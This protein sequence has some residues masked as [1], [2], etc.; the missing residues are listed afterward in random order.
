MSKWIIGVI[1]LLAIGSTILYLDQMKGRKASDAEHLSYVPA[2][3]LIFFSA[4]NNED[5]LEFVNNM[6]INAS[7][8]S[9]QIQMKHVSQILD[10]QDSPTARFFTTLFKPFMNGELQSFTDMQRIFGTSAK[11]PFLTYTDGIFPVIRVGLSNPENFWA[12]IENSVSESGWQY[13]TETILNQEVKT[14][15][16]DTK[17]S[18]NQ[19]KL[20]IHDH[21]N[22]ATITILSSID[23]EQSRQQRLALAPHPNSIKTS[24]EIDDLKNKYQFQD[25]F[26][27]FVHF[28]R[29]ADNLL[30]L[31]SG[32]LGQ[33]LNA[34]LP[35]EQKSN[36]TTSLSE[37]CKKD[38]AALAASVPRLAMGYKNLSYANKQLRGD[39]DVVLELTN[40]NIKNELSLLRGH[41]PAHSKDIQDKIFTAG[42]GVNFTTVTPA[43]TN[44]WTQFVNAEFQCEK[45]HEAQDFARKGNPAMLAMF[46]GMAQGIKGLGVSLFE[47]DWNPQQMVVNKLSALVSVASESP[48]T[49][50]GMTS[51]IPM[52]SGLQIPADG[53][54]VEVPLAMLP[55]NSKISAAI[56]GNHF[57]VYTEDLSD[58]AAA[59]ETEV[60][61]TNGLS[62]FGINYR[63]FSKISGIT[64]TA[65]I[66][67]AARCISNEELRHIFSTMP[68][69]LL[70]VT[71]SS[72]NGL[73]FR[74]SMTLDTVTHSKA[75]LVGQHQVEYL[76][77]NC[78]WQ[79]AGQEILTVD[80]NGNYIERDESDSCDVF[81]SQ[82]NWKEEGQR[83]VF[84]PTKESS[85]ESCADEMADGELE[86]YDC[87]LMN[88]SGNQFQCLFDAGTEDAA[89]YRYT[90][91]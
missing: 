75:A 23:S 35:E 4:K 28:S 83:I 78:Q 37:N 49:I 3:T 53:T 48:Q 73:E 27:S 51:M 16:F 72:D 65:G 61:E 58:S 9:Q 22:I 66:S 39:F 17:D 76:D 11:G 6:P 7:S 12:T 1:A 43:L 87:Y 84:T 2:D 59:L 41:I 91:S 86:S 56:K 33:Q 15:Q 90:R 8:P 69:D 26:I 74:S 20:A 44:L 47:L 50:A 42:F 46:L 31:E 52:L 62:S 80:G 32:T 63:Q 79:M 18:P 34:L 45:L 38:Y 36:F 60:L 67:S 89:L 5:L 10:N 55:V 71:D 30:N 88:T 40:T 19:F 57:V 29:I 21:D 14:W 70:M 64:N 85:R 25:S 54:P 81:T 82:Y 68:M 77:E 24:K 13:Q